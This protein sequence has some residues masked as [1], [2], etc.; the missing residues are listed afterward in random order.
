MMTL[1]SYFTAFTSLHALGVHDVG[2][3]DAHGLH[4]VEDDDAHGLHG[5]EDDDAHGLHGHYGCDLEE[6]VD[7]GE[8][9]LVVDCHCGGDLEEHGPH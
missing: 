7:D 6:H 9:A 4:G 8:G 5:V 3:D 2:V 1:Q